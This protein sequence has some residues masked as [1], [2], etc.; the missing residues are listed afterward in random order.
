MT[1]QIFSFVAGPGKADFASGRPGQVFGPGIVTHKI[2]L[3]GSGLF[4]YVPIFLGQEPIVFR[5]RFVSGI[6]LVHHLVSESV[7]DLYWLGLRPWARLRP[8]LG[9]GPGPRRRTGY[10]PW[11]RFLA[12][13]R[14][15]LLLHRPGH[16]LGRFWTGQGVWHGHR[17]GFDIIGNRDFLFF[18]GRLIG[19]VG[20]QIPQQGHQGRSMEKDGQ[21]G[22]H[23]PNRRVCYE[24]NPTP[25]QHRPRG[26]AT[27]PVAFRSRRNR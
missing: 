14:V 10:C 3:A 24:R 25:W 17:H 20:A 23:Q 15:L 12:G 9:F 27:L 21:N 16:G 22:D 13:F 1:N 18:L 7:L 2:R 5:S 19:A 26:S 8:G 4:S 6:R 11:L